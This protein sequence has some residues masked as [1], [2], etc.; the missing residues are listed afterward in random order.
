MLSVVVYACVRRPWLTIAL[1]LLLAF[2]SVTAIR[3]Q[4]GV[5]TDTGRLFSA[6]L[7]WKQRSAELQ[8]L[9]PQ[10][11]DLLVAV[12]DAAIPE[13]AEGTAR[14]RTAALQAD[15]RHFSAVTQP[16]ASPYLE[17][18]AF[19][20]LDKARLQDVLDRTID[21]QPFLG[22]LTADPSLRCL[23]AALG[24]TAEGVKA[25]QANLTPFL[26]AL[27]GFHDGLAAVAGKPVPLSWERLLAGPG[28]DLA[29]RVHFVA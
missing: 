29:R 1:A 25:G 13:E 15:P 22:Q 23:F 5:A 11:E 16:D 26:P 12:I 17:R 8:K 4:L 9:F 19:L 6:S 20:F 28:A 10:N 27:R 14:Q 18:N 3:T 2:G 7:P 21:A 24:L